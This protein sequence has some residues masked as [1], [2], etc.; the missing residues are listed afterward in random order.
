MAAESK[1]GPH[2]PIFLSGLRSPHVPLPTRS[3]SGSTR[4]WVGCFPNPFASMRIGSAPWWWNH[5]FLLDSHFLLS[6]FLFSN[7]RVKEV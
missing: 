3:F 5:Y 7:L 2:F 4:A 1:T 6:W